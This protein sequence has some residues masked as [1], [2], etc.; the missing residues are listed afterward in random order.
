[1]V[2]LTIWLI[3]NNCKKNSLCQIMKIFSILLLFSKK[4]KCMKNYINIFFI[5]SSD[6]YN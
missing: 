3:K 6:I 4:N 1:M 5:D 2:N